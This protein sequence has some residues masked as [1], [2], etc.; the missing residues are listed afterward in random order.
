M[1]ILQ[2]FDNL[3]QRL[4]RHHTGVV[5]SEI[6]LPDQGPATKERPTGREGEGAAEGAVHDVVA[7]GAILAAHVFDY[8]PQMNADECR[9]WGTRAVEPRAEAGS[10]LGTDRLGYGGNELF[11]GKRFLQE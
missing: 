2:P 7:P 5:S 9:S 10:R 1:G 8:G 4:Q 6:A 11:E 3:P